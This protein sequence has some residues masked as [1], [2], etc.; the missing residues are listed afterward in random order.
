YLDVQVDPVGSGP[1]RFDAYV[2]GVRLEFSAN[3]GY[4]LGAPAIKRLS[5]PFVGSET[6]AAQA[7][8]DGTNDWLPGLDRS[9]YDQIKDDPELRFVEYLE[10]SFLGLY[11]NL[12]PE[13]DALFLDRNLRQAVAYCLDKPATVAL[14]THGHGAPI[15]SEI[16]PVS[17]AYPAAGLKT[18]P[19]DQ[20]MA[21]RLIEASGWTTGADGIYEKAGRKLATVVAVRSGFPQRSRWLALLGDQVR[22]CGIDIGY[23]EVGFAAIVAMLDVYPHRNAAEPALGRPFDAYFGGLTV[24][25]DPDPFRLYHSSECSTAER[26]S[27]FNHICYA[28]PAVDR[29]IEAGLVTFEQAERA[30]IY[31]QYAV[32]Q[33][34]DLPVL[35]AWS[36]RLRDALRATVGTTATGGLRLDTPTWFR[37]GEKLTNVR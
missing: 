9:I 18:Y 16:P 37:E 1:F 19:R 24:G 22:E 33:S 35:Y 34:D 17:W 15:Y 8:V 11:F 2:P 12:H 10:P 20:V 28:N 23:R 36:D 6:D 13:S 14:A 3:N 4:F 31:Q 26:P 30:R 32:L 25:R 21:R 29:L 7:L 27:T 5:F